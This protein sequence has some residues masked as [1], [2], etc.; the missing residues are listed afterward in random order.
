[1]ETST[2]HWTTVPDGEA[3]LKVSLTGPGSIPASTFTQSFRSTVLKHGSRPALR[4]KRDGRWITWT[5]E[6][7]YADAT[8]AAKSMIRLGLE[9][10][11][12][13]GII[14]FNS[15]EWLLSY[16]GCILAG[17]IAT[18]IYTT[19]TKEACHYIADNS[20]AQIFICEDK[21]QL[22][23]L[24]QVRDRLPHLKVIVKYIPESIEP[25]DPEMKESGV[26]TWD[27]FMEKGQGIPDYELSWRMDHQKPGHCASLIYTSGTTGPPKGVMLSHDNIVWSSTILAKSYDATEVESHI[28]YLPL[29]HIAGQVVDIVTP[30]L[31]G[32]CVWFAQP[33]ALKGSLKQTI[34]D[35]HPTFFFAVPRVW[36]KFKDALE[37]EL[38]KASGIKAA[39]INA[40]RNVGR[41]TQA[42]RLQG[43]S[44]AW[45]YW[46]A[47]KTCFNSLRDK[48]GLDRCRLTV[49]AAAPLPMAITEFFGDF[50]IPVFQ[51]YGM[52]ETTGVSC[53]NCQGSYKPGAAGR[54]LIGIEIKIDKPDSE[55][56]GEICFRGRHVFMGYLYQAE[57]TAECVDEDGWLH[58]GDIGRIDDD[59]F[60]YITGR[61]KEIIITKGGENVAP[62]PIEQNMKEKI[63]II[64]NVMIVGDE[65]HYLTMLVTIRCVLL[66]GR[67]PTDDMD[68]I[69]K[70]VAYEIGSSAT[71]VSEAMNDDVIKRYIQ[72]G[73]EQAN[74]QA[75]SRAAKVQKFAILP[76]D[77]SVDGGELTPTFKLK[78]KF[79]TEKYRDIIDQ[80]YSE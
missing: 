25:L 73:M 27:E 3:L 4:V 72:Q 17:G 40:S 36:E 33:D 11:Y 52:S 20:R 58:S 71:T 61:L 6:Q 2:K 5:Y 15:P 64:S 14:G 51:A 76:L 34:L 31:I 56:D 79:V 46:L 78:R 77:F 9:Q 68:S 55:G 50:D 74:E 8:R 44:V 12:G 29:S 7:Y 67:Q 28:S 45:G 63:R 39:I 42:N 30:A 22:T 18:G 62:V 19:N 21:K 53:L 60:Y 59:G 69:A 23:K 24:L 16:M 57:K 65:R 47:Q 38:A 75:I 49:S 26:M 35:V 37:I 80:L 70:Q 13:V 10:H 1:M 32:S 48:L 43:Q 54:S 41:K 66:D